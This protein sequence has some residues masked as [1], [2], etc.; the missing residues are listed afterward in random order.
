MGNEATVIATS[1][2]ENF[3]ELESA[4]AGDGKGL[5]FVDDILKDG[6]EDIT[7]ENV[8]VKPVEETKVEETKVEET[9]V[10]ETPAVE[11]EETPAAKADETAKPDEEEETPVVADK[12]QEVNAELR[13]ELR[14]QGRKTAI[15][16]AKLNRLAETTEVDLSEEG[17]LDEDDTA[18]PAKKTEELSSIEKLQ[19]E[20]SDVGARRGEAFSDMLEL[21]SLG[22]VP[23]IKDV[24]TQARFDD[25]FDAAARQ[26]VEAD[27]GDLAATQL[28]LEVA[29]WKM[30]NPYQYMYDVIKKYHPDFEEPA[31]KETKAEDGKETTLVAP[32]KEAEERGKT[33]VKAPTTALD[34][35]DGGS[36]KDN[37]GW[38]PERIDKLDEDELGQVPDD[39][40]QKYLAGQLDK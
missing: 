38:T 6:Q 24:C 16:E 1:D 9:K 31:T 28:A 30:G 10:E 14:T 2:E 11:E 13:R 33:L 3:D 25:I 40:Y 8:V 26:K 19:N 22:K 17:D 27:G 34:I 21:M 39:I 23:D 32:T 37:V 18:I 12:L 35:G 36:G 29:V 7:A 5:D 20:L 4:L 15:M